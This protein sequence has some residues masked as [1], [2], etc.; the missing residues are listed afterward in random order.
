[1]L[2]KYGNC[3]SLLKI[4]NK[5]KI[6]DFT[7]KVGKNALYFVDVRLLL[8]IRRYASRLPSTISYPGRTRGI[9]VKYSENKCDLYFSFV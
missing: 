4:K 6:G 1:M 3:T 2:S 5:L 7:N 8:P 9:I